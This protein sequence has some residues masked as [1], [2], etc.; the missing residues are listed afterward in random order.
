MAQIKFG[1]IS[2]QGLAL[3]PAGKRLTVYDTK[4]GRT[5]PK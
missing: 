3:P 2:L 5:L 4:T 1:K